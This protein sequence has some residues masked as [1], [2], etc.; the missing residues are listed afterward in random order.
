MA[1]AAARTLLE[2]TAMTA[3]LRAAV[4]QAD[5]AVAEGADQVAPEDQVAPAPLG[6][7]DNR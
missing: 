6:T 1:A 7:L 2:V 3:R 4:A 5:R